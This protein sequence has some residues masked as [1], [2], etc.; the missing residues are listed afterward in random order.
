MSELRKA[1]LR[2]G[3]RRPY[4]DY[5]AELAAGQGCSLVEQFEAVMWQV[6]PAALPAPKRWERMVSMADREAGGK[7]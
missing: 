5:L 1:L 6:A 2:C 3:V 7:R 4:V